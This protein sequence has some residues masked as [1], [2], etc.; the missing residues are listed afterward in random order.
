M[1]TLFWKVGLLLISGILIETLGF[2]SGRVF[3]ALALAGIPFILILLILSFVFEPIQRVLPAR[4]WIVFFLPASFLFLSLLVPEPPVNPPQ[5]WFHFNSDEPD[6]EHRFL[7]QAR[8]QES[9]NPGLYL[10]RIQILDYQ[11]DRDP[12]YY[13]E[14]WSSVLDGE[15]HRHRGDSLRSQKSK[16]QNFEASGHETSTLLDFPDEIQR[17]RNQPFRTALSVDNQHLFTG[18]ALKLQVFGRG[19]PERPTGGFGQYLRSKGARSYLRVYKKWHVLKTHCPSGIRTAIRSRLMNLLSGLDQQ[20]ARVARAIMLGESGWM[21]RDFRNR[22][23]RLGIMHLFAA[24]GLHLGIFYGLLFLPLSL[25]LG[26]KHPATLFLPLI[27]CALYVW[28]LFFPVSLCRAFAFIL[29]LAL[30]SVLH[31]KI[32]V[33]HHLANTG[34]LLL[35]WDPLGFYSLSG[36]LSF[37]AVSGILI[38]YKRI[39]RG[40]FSSKHWFATLF[41]SQV[42]LSLSASMFITPLLVFSFQEYPFSSH[43]SNIIMVPF[44]GLMLPPLYLLILLRMIPFLDGPF[45]QLLWQKV[46]ILLEWFIWLARSMSQYCVFFE[47][48]SWWN[49]AFVLSWLTMILLIVSVTPSPRLARYSVRMAVAFIVLGALLSLNFSDGEFWGSGSISDRA[50]PESED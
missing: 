26:R 39:E 7:A 48:D 21:E 47:Y 3:L 4:R 16:V 5:Y 18:C 9:I 38:F 13:G 17:L 10:A 14:D 23:R 45:L 25:G 22:I 41:R 49:F 46:S 33:E 29:L 40:L 30:R 8:I 12:T 44:V 34:I 15:D 36:Y 50:F 11:K 42:A 19:V 43:L 32:G 35:F 27:P 24:S 2:K 31:R 1:R 28:I 6:Y 37:G 20:P